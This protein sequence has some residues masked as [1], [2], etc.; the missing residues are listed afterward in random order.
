MNDINDLTSKNVAPPKVPLWKSMLLIAIILVAALGIAA[1]NIYIGAVAFIAAILL[2]TYG[3]FSS[4]AHIAGETRARVAAF[5][6]AWVLCVILAAA[7]QS[8]IPAFDDVLSSF[9]SG[10]PLPTRIAQQIYPLALLAPLI[11]GLVWR[12]WPNRQKRLRLAVV[13]CWISIAVIVLLMGSMYLPI[14]VLG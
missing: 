11:V 2:Q 10:L 14:W 7:L 5:A 1:G 12:F 9:G 6:F 3:G 13:T 8:F 4:A